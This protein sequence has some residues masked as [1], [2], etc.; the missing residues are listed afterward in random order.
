MSLSGSVSL[1]KRS[2]SALGADVPAVLGTERPFPGSLT[3]TSP[4]PAAELLASLAPERRDR[5][6]GG[7]LIPGQPCK[8][9][10]GRQDPGLL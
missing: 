6:L 5:G 10:D 3:L 1:G 7:C 2:P 9:S 8:S 4:D